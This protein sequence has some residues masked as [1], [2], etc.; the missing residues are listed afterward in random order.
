MGGGGKE[1]GEAEKKENSAHSLH[2]GSVKG[3][4]IYFWLAGF[5]VKKNQVCPS[6]SC[7]DTALSTVWGDEEVLGPDSGD[8]CTALRMYLVPL[9]CTLVS[10]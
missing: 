6:P 7:S 4:I 2:T 5:Y 8:G 9:N 1:G 10:G 3:K